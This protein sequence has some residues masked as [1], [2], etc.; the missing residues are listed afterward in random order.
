[1]VWGRDGGVG[2]GGGMVCGEDGG[3]G[4]MGGEGWWVVGRMVCGCGGG[5]VV[6]V[7]GEGWV[8]GRDGGVGEG[9]WCGW[10]MNF[11]CGM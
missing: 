5:M 8:W 7:M 6:W 10:G 11:L 4:W 9:W 2:D 3:V 1:M